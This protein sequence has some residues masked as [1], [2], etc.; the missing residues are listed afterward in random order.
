MAEGK[1]EV[2]MM[3]REAGTWL[4]LTEVQLRSSPG[5]V[6]C[7]LLFKISYIIFLF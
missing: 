5:S 2:S 7:S 1:D 4:L 6:D 3:N